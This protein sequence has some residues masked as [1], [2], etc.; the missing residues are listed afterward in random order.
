MNTE[1]DSLGKFIKDLTE[2]CPDCNKPLELRERGEDSLAQRYKYCPHCS[3]EKRIGY[4]EK[5]RGYANKKLQTDYEPR[6][7]QSPNRNRKDI[8]RNSKNF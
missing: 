3:Y 2:L 5:G 8:G 6:R 1:D 4:K 7:E